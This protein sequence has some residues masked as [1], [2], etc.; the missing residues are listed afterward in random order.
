M[1]KIDLNWDDADVLPQKLRPDVE[2]LLRRMNAATIEMTDPHLAEIILDVGCGRAIDI[3]N[4]SKSG[5]VLIG[6]EP[7]VVMLTHA[8]E[9]LK[10]DGNNTAVLQAIGESIPVVPGSMDKVICK[11]ALDHF[12]DPRKA[13][14]QMAKAVKPEG[15][16]I[17]AIANFESLGFKIGKLIFWSRKILG[18]ANPYER[19]PWELPAD[20]TVKFDF[21]LI[22]KMLKEYLV[23]DKIL[24]VSM[25]CSMPGWGDFLAGLPRKV[26]E[27][28]LKL[29]DALSRLL[30]CISDVVVVR[31]VAD[32]SI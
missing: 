18:I 4:M 9:S 12:A 8:Q 2:F 29:L 14:E 10:M 17:I 20:H 1:N 26:T 19:L 31:C 3:V 15:Q 5:A 22:M 21:N 23:V 7:S 28:L 24:G 30:P 27:L 6:L 11:G 32:E 13:I 25:L 16:V